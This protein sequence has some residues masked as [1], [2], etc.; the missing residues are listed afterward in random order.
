MIDIHFSYGIGTEP[1]EVWFP[2]AA[3]WF[4]STQRQNENEGRSFLP[5]SRYLPFASEVSQMSE[6]LLLHHLKINPGFI[7]H[8]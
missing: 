2:K 1:A 7:L 3:L 6:V 8:I 4:N 5:S